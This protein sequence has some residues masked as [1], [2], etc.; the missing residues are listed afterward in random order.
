MTFTVFSRDVL[1]GD[2]AKTVDSL[3]GLLGI[4][5]ATEGD[6][7]SGFSKLFQKSGCGSGSVRLQWTERSETGH[8]QDRKVE[9]GAILEDILQARAVTANQAES[10]RGRMHWLSQ[11]LSEELLMGR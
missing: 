10:L 2:T 4:E 3:F 1:A 5:I 9:I 11:S 7:A 6:K 8:T